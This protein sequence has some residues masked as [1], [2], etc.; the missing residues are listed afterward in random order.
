MIQP[1]SKMMQ[2]HEDDNF[3]YEAIRAIALTRYFGADISEVLSTLPSI[4]AGNF[5]DWYREWHSLALRVL[6]TVD[7]SKPESYSPITLRDVYFRASE[8]FFVSEF[9]LHGNPSDPRSDAAYKLWRRYFD[10]A[11]EQLPIPGKRDMIPT[12]DGFDV[13]IMVF[14]TPE[15]SESNRRPTIIVGGGFDSNHEE[16]MHVFGFSALERGFNVVLYEGPGQPALLHKQKQGWIP[17][18]EEVVTPVVDHLIAGQKSGDLAFVD[19]ENLGLIGHSLGG[20]LSERAAAFEP[21]LAA[22]MAID[23][24]WSFEDCCLKVFTDCESA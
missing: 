9:F 17:K 6:S 13:P 19:T 22:L 23:G 21:R 1:L 2:F 18:W 11:N 12:K 5:D 15:A 3:H 4:H 10:L 24:V 8:Y 20:Y 14:R 7:E 16:T